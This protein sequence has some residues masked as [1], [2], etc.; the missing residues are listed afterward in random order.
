[1]HVTF[2]IVLIDRFWHNNVPPTKTGTTVLLMRRHAALCDTK[3]CAFSY[4]NNAAETA[5]GIPIAFSFPIYPPWPIAWNGIYTIILCPW[6]SIAMRIHWM[7]EWRAWLWWL[8]T[9]MLVLI[10]LRLLL[11]DYVWA[12][13][14]LLWHEFVGFVH[15]RLLTRFYG[16]FMMIRTRKDWAHRMDAWIFWNAFN[17]RIRAVQNLNFGCSKGLYFTKY[18]FIEWALGVGWSALLKYET[19]NIV[20]VEFGL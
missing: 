10:H 15:V 8:Q 5:A 1:M 3:S 17:N 14:R 18:A 2:I 20:G 11:E 6:V 9:I 12:E 4:K 7:I 13:L 19:M 16:I